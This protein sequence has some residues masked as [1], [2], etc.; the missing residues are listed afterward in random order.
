MVILL[1]L[2]CILRCL[3]QTAIWQI[4]W[5]SK[6]GVLFFDLMVETFLKKSVCVWGGCTYTV[7][8]V[9]GISMTRNWRHILLSPCVQ[10]D[11][12]ESTLLT[13]L[14]VSL[15]HQSSKVTAKASSSPAPKII[16][17]IPER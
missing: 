16:T 13:I 10:T 14:K 2:C 1:L 7:I 12:Q 6:N 4:L 9:K 15:S 11:M 8:H 17:V 5:F 3:C